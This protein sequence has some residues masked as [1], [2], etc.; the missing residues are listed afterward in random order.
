MHPEAVHVP[1][2]KTCYDYYEGNS[3]GGSCPY[4]GRGTVEGLTS[5]VAL[6]EVV[7]EELL[8]IE[9][10]RISV[11]KINRKN[12]VKFRD[13]LNYLPDFHIL[14]SHTSDVLANLCITL[15]LV[16]GVEK[17]VLGGGVMSRSILF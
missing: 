17:I 10:H 16:T 3:Y 12:I 2:V 1:T 11:D 13:K 9:S 15:L 7:S 6:S 14:W 4:N 8:T 5:S